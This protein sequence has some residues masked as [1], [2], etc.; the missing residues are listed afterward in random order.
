MSNTLGR[1][2]SQSENVNHT[3]YEISVGCEDGAAKIE[4]LCA[5]KDKVSSCREMIPVLT[6]IAFDI[7]TA[8]SGFSFTLKVQLF[9]HTIWKSSASFVP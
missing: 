2:L 7:G 5:Q 9:E 6:L 3:C 1:V 8:L 4:A